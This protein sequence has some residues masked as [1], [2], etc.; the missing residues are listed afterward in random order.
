MK[1]NITKVLALTLILSLMVCVFVGCARQVPSGTYQSELSLAGQS[2]KFSYT[3]QGSK[4]TAETKLTL[5]GTVNSKSVSGTYEITEN[6]DGTME[7]TLNFE[8][9]TD[10]LKNGTFTYEEGE[11]YIKLAGVQYNKV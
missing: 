1:K 3:I 5:F 7:I 8:E 4:V 11:N 2:Y 6:A 9:E 10:V